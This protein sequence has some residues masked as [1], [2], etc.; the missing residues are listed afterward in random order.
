[1]ALQ[2]HMWYTA[3][4]LITSECPGNL[5]NIFYVMSYPMSM[6]FKSAVG[7]YRKYSSVTA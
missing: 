3:M 5:A 2:R 1:M 4:V 6:S 7:I